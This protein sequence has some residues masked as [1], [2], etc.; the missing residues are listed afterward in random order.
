MYSLGRQL[1]VGRVALLTRGDGRLMTKRER[2]WT[3]VIN[4][5]LL[6][7]LAAANSCSSDRTV[8]PRSEVTREALVQAL[9]P[10]LGA[11]VS[12]D[13][14]LPMS[15]VENTGRA[16]ISAIAA[17]ALAVGVAKYN[18]P[19]NNTVLEN[20]RGGAIDY[21]R[22]SSCRPASYVTT[23]FERIAVDNPSAAAHP[24]QKALGPFWLVTLCARGTPQLTVGVS[25]YSTD[26]G[27]GPNGEVLFPP[28][29]GNDFVAEGI[30]QAR[31]G[32]ELPSAEAAV[33]LAATAT[34]RRVAALPELLLPFY[35][36][37]TPSGA[38]W[39]LRLDSPAR[40]ETPNGTVETSDVYVSRIHTTNRPGSRT[41]SANATQPSQVDVLLIPMIRV[42]E[43]NDAYVQRRDAETQTLHVPLRS[44]RPI[45]FA[46]AVTNA[47]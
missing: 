21:Q 14:F 7:C 2:H 40:V 25:A 30:P 42:G 15:S 43:N 44:G 19:Y 24:L 8:A 22:L 36:E 9:T 38:R 4:V 28:I 13:G 23:P 47:H 3:S 39:H 33:V 29:G 35:T 46:P 20:Q 5:A 34:N 41:W 18:L 31:P 6:A 37:E 1:S 10:E 27:L 11:V 45:S 12:S 32:D 16:Q 17:A 26:L